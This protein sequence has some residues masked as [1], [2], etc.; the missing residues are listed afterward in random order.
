MQSF[1]RSFVVGFDLDMTLTD[2]RAGIARVFQEVSER[3]GVFID[4]DL[5]ISRL[6]PPLEWELGQWFPP[7]RV[8][9]AAALYRSMYELAVPLTTELPGAKDAV[10]AVHR[11]GGKVIVITAKH[12]ASAE[13]SLRHL[14]FQVD[15]VV[16]W[17]WAEAKGDAL[18]ERGGVIYVGDHPGD[19]RAAR[20][21][22][23]V[24]VGVR[25]GGV[26]P[27]GADVLFDDLTAFPAWLDEY[28]LDAR[29]QALEA[30]LRELGS[31]VVAFSGGADSA[32]LLAAAVRALGAENVVAATAVSSSLPA[33]EL[34]AARAFA[35]GLGVRH[36]TPATDEMSRDGYQANAG[37]RCYF[38]KAELVDVLGPLAGTEGKAHVLTGTNADD[39][40]HDFRPGI[41]A[42]AER[43]AR[44]P[45]LDAGFTKAQVRE[46]SRRWGLTTWD[47][48][49]AACLSSRV[50]YGVR[51]TPK[52]LARV[53]AAEAALREALADAGIPV[54][55]L[56]VRDL[57]D[58]ARIE[59]DRELVPAVTAST[60]ALA[61]VE[62]AGFDRVEVDTQGFRSG[63]MNEL[64]R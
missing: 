34:A 4:V 27:Q 55:N 41:R 5:V 10:A 44:T 42:A 14:G 17:R 56:R 35:A 64:L 62:A 37:N 25:T 36:L 12:A 54:R 63:S 19:V 50:A 21:A 52:R 18:R 2:S 26:E 3:T 11:L 51:I 23:A 22:D 1:A 24:A 6:G 53:E 43:G 30:A 20:A 58:H 33:T 8:D 57:G 15:E 38:C 61:A 13:A 9:E 46:A 40:A 7:E 48:P 60:A 59:V 45:L 16:G 31:V 49:A 32:F 39:A 28:V 47:K 29:L